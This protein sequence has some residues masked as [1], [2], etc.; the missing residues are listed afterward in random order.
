MTFTEF[1][2]NLDKKRISRIKNSSIMITGTLA[3]LK[4]L[5]NL[6]H[7]SADDS[8]LT[9]D[10]E[11]IDIRSLV[12][13]ARSS[14][15]KDYKHA[16]HSLSSVLNKIEPSCIKKAGKELIND[17]SMLNS[18]TKLKARKQDDASYSKIVYS[19]PFKTYDFNNLET[20]P[21]NENVVTSQSHQ[22]N[23]NPVSNIPM[24][25][26]IDTLDVNKLLKNAE[27]NASRKDYSMALTNIKSVFN[28]FDT[29]SS[30]AQKMICGNA[31]DVL[32]H[33]AE[34]DLPC[35]RYA[36]QLLSSGINGIFEP[37]CPKALEYLQSGE[38]KTDPECIFQTALIY[39]SIESDQEALYYM[40]KAA[41]M[42]Y[43]LIVVI[44][45]P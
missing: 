9:D 37:D 25:L 16:L 18:I 20:Q 33:C 2:S 26:F 23:N 5:S 6:S 43:Y 19:N 10:E 21:I 4:R 27:I 8:S 42:F 29:L 40:T 45:E 13:S 41:K 34:K 39:Q 24:D 15:L 11:I 31:M 12:A 14:A 38:R 44:L 36:C 1:L 30:K 7:D 35:A 32:E 17:P 22:T 28:Q 3:D